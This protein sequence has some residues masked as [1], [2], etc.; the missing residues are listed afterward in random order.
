MPGQLRHVRPIYGWGWTDAGGA[1][2]DT[3]A[4]FRLG[5]DDPDAI[6]G[7][8]LGDHEFAGAT[9]CLAPRHT[10]PDGI[11]SIEIRRDAVPLAQGYAEA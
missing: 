8:V 10:T 11:F 2:R 6:Q 5:C 4:P 9:A 3:P 7:I 1:T